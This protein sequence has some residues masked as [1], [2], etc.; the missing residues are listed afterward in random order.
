MIKVY[1]VCFFNTFTDL[2]QIDDVFLNEIDAN[3]CAKNNL[4]IYNGKQMEL[5]VLERELKGNNLDLIKALNSLQ[6]SSKRKKKRK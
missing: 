2:V 3:R 4:A 6:K 1:I 5:Q